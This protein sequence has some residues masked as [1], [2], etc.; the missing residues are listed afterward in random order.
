MAKNLQTKL[1]PCLLL[2]YAQHALTTCT[3]GTVVP[4]RKFYLPYNCNQQ[5]KCHT[6]FCYE[7]RMILGTA[8]CYIQTITC[9]YKPEISQ[10]SVTILGTHDDCKYKQWQ[11]D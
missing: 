7:N 5:N 9:M 8:Y 1:L 2:N 10:I 11:I 3:G 6:D 4:K